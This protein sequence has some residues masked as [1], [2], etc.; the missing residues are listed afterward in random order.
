MG[1]QFVKLSLI[2]L[3]FSTI[4]VFINSAQTKKDGPFTPRPIPKVWDKE[5][6]GSVELPLATADASPVHVNEEYYYSIPVRKIYKSYPIYAP[7]KE[8][9]GYLDWLKQQEPEVTFDA[10]KLKTEEDWIKAG[11]AVF[12]APIFYNTI[13]NFRDSKFYE[14][15]GM[16]LTKEGATVFCRYVIREKGK[17]EIGIASCA[18]CHTRIMPDGTVIKGAQSNVP[19]DRVLAYGWRLGAS[20]TS[21]VARLTGMLRNEELSSFSAPWLKPDPHESFNQMSIEEMAKLHEVIPPGVLARQR[22][23]PFF[24]VHVPDLIGIKE[25]RYLDSS[26]LVRHRDIGD[27]MRYAALAQGGDSLSSF[28]EFIPDGEEF[29]KLPDP[30]NLSRYSDEQLYALA[31]YIYSLKPPPNPNKFGDLAKRGEKVFKREGCAMCH[32]PPAYTNNKLTPAEGF[33]VP[34][35]HFKKYAILPLSVGTDPNLTLKTRRGT[36]YYKVPSLKGV[37]YRGPFGHSGS[38]AT[39]EDWFNPERLHDDYVPTGFRGLGISTQAVKG[40]PF[41]LNL[42]Q[43]DRQALI[44]FLKTL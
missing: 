11:E 21:N 42:S 9:P 29:R 41:G 15:T 5:A 17:V 35:E 13:L 6:L 37:W 32:T 16:P 18:D 24:P 31:L 25:R 30:K 12:A 19:L 2:I 38:V 23:S 22:S 20:K 39:L 27:L 34:E 10:S 36:G 14:K 28:G 43:D 40:H 1:K 44:A 33:K 4:M 3:C 26:G 8:P 7:D